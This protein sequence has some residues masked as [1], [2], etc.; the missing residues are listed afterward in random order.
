MSQQWLLP[1]AMP[2]NDEIEMRW[3][4]AW[5][6]LYEIVRDNRD[7]QCLLPDGEVVD[8]EACKGWLQ[9]SAYQGFI[10]SVEQGRVSGK[11]G[12]I[13]ARVPDPDWE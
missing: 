12:V 11:R 13:A 8:I 2:T 1:F 5:S 3:V 4:D 10:P 9:D 6:D 7:V